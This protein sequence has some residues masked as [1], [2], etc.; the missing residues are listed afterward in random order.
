MR[1]ASAE[2]KKGEINAK[3][4]K[5]REAAFVEKM[6]TPVSAATLKALLSIDY[7][8]DA[9]DK[10][11]R[12]L[13]S[14][15]EKGIVADR[16]FLEADKE[17]GIIIRTISD[18]RESHVRNLSNILDVKEAN[19]QMLSLAASLFRLPIMPL[20]MPPLSSALKC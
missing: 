18:S 17:K 2:F 3:M 11:I 10:I 1:I 6:G 20:K 7:N 15:M 5:P 12:I 19:Q 16:Y 4:L 13:T 9:Q 8:K 14:V